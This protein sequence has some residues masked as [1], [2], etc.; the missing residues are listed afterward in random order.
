MTEVLLI[1]L[2]VQCSRTEENLD[3]MTKNSYDKVQI[4]SDLPL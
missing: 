2:V 1:A 4:V 3:M